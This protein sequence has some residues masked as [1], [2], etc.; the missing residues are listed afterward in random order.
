MCPGVCEPGIATEFNTHLRKYR[1]DTNWILVELHEQRCNII[2]RIADEY[3]A[4]N[5][6]NEALSIHTV[7]HMFSLAK[8]KS[9]G[10]DN[11]KEI[12]DAY[13]YLTQTQSMTAYFESVYEEYFTQYEANLINNLAESALLNLRIDPLA[14]LDLSD[15]DNNALVLTET[16]TNSIYPKLGEFFSL[17]FATNDRQSI[18]EYEEALSIFKKSDVLAQLKILVEKKLEQENFLVNFNK[19]T[20]ENAQHYNLRLP[21]GI[22]VEMLCTLN[23]TLQNAQDN[24]QQIR[25]I[26]TDNRKLVEKYPCLIASAV[27]A[28]PKLWRYLP[29]TLRNH[30]AFLDSLIG[31]ID[32]VT[33]EKIQNGNADDTDSQIEL[34]LMMIK[35]NYDFLKGYSSSFFL[36]NIEIALKL[37]AK[38]GFLYKYLSPALQNNKQVMDYALEQNPQV[39]KYFPENRQLQLN[40]NTDKLINLGVEF[41]NNWA[42]SSL[43]ERIDKSESVLSLLETEFVS[44]ST[45]TQLAQSL[46]PS[47]LLWI[48]KARQ[49]RGLQ[50][51]PELTEEGLNQFIEALELRD[52]GW[53][54]NYL[55]FKRT[56]PP[57]SQHLDLNFSFN[58]RY[59]KELAQRCV[60]R[61]NQ[62]LTAF[63]AF[64]KQIPV[65]YKPFSGSEDVLDQLKLTGRIAFSFLKS[66]GESLLVLGRLGLNYA[67]TLLPPLIDFYLTP[68]LLFI[69]N[70]IAAYTGGLFLLWML[71]LYGG[72]V[73][74]NNW[75]DNKFNPLVNLALFIIALSAPTFFITGILT[76]EL[77]YL[78]CYVLAALIAASSAVFGTSW[79]LTEINTLASTAL[80]HWLLANFYF[81]IHSIEAVIHFGLKLTVEW[82]K[83]FFALIVPWVTRSIASCSNTDSHAIGD[84]LLKIKVENSI[85]RLLGSDSVSANLKGTVLESLWQKIQLDV[86]QSEGTLTF[87]KALNRK[88]IF[89]TD[90]KTCEKSFME[91]A[92]T[93]R[94]DKEGFNLNTTQTRYSFFCIKSKTS[95]A[96][97]LQNYADKWVDDDETP[98]I[99]LV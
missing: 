59:H 31:K 62:W 4:I 70:S 12:E 45:L 38:N 85:S 58:Q 33:Q 61:S 90:G 94:Q 81:V 29:G 83:H 26:L 65:Y 55:N 23:E 30:S 86:K 71:Q 16:E 15:W 14:E 77:V 73:I 10:V 40:S 27:L 39:S 37:V 8:N 28:N 60:A 9:L 5:H 43:V 42:N 47:E 88:Y 72:S 95:T 53:E 96:S 50:N 75:L 54:P 46:S 74:I 79:S 21:T 18:V 20:E 93:H 68:Y 11:E 87:E 34:L 52:R 2:Q 92:E 51:L 24:P 98:A 7:M 41:H 56:I 25:Q 19:L 82:P 67:V 35:P 13:S 89:S 36:S 22:S 6:V 91:V 97:N 78:G 3:N 63:F 99:V 84:D 48:I 49:Q 32:F 66:I 57:N 44:L 76:L 69:V 80:S 1:S 64:Q 17:Y